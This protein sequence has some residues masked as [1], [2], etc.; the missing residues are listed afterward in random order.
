MA[1]RGVDVS[2]IQ[3]ALLRALPARFLAALAPRFSRVLLEPKDVVYD[4]GVPIEHVYFPE[5]GLISIVGTTR[6]G[7][8][9]EV[10]TIG[11][12]GMVGLPVFLGVSQ[13][14]GHA[15]S[16][17]AGPALRMKSNTFRK[18]ARKDGPLRELMER[19]TQTLFTLIAQ[20]AAC[21]RL[22]VNEERFAR[23]LLLCHD[24]IGSDQFPLT[25]QFISQMLGVRRA[26]VSSVAST[27]QR[28]GLIRYARGTITIC[29]RNALEAAA[30]ECYSIIR[31]EYDSLFR[32]AR[33]APRRSP[34]ALL[35]TREG[36]SKTKDGS[37]KP[38][39]N[40]R[41]KS[42]GQSRP[43]VTNEERGGP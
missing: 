34:I 28:E 38:R 13:T 30:C 5:G 10:A 35:T 16:Q 24:R 15:F 14:A 19:Y 22:H 6:D 36:K 21:N 4:N 39:H 7:S 18:I 31:A 42:R 11:K 32:S 9:V 37:P 25:Q 20:S 26:T 41:H 29:D 8:A 2:S 40:P 23:W 12:E 17:V 27:L 33:A 43:P 1:R 3:S